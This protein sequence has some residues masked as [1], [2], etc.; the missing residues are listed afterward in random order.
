MPPEGFR[1]QFEGEQAELF[2]GGVYVRL[3]LKNSQFPLR[4]PKVCRPSLHP[5]KPSSALSQ[6]S[7]V[8]FCL[9]FP[10]TPGKHGF[11]LAEEADPLQF[12]CYRAMSRSLSSLLNLLCAGWLKRLSNLIANRSRCLPILL[13]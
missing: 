9:G 10:S 13:G 12:I 4:H 11:G 3:F 6:F 5:L 8:V 1:I 7:V 2:I